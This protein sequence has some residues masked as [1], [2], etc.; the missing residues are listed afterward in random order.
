ML[1]QLHIQELEALVGNLQTEVRLHKAQ[2]EAQQWE[3]ALYQRQLHSAQESQKAATSQIHL[4]K[5]H[6][7]A[8]ELSIPFV[9]KIVKEVPQPSSR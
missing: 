9:E 4:L 3:L 7:K 5:F 8:V 1:D 6:P 2:M